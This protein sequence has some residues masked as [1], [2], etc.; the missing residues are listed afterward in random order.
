MK[1]GPL[2][3]ALAL[4]MG[5][6]MFFC[7][8]WIQRGAGSTKKFASESGNLLPELVWIRTSL[9]LTDSQFERVQALHLAY[10][11]KCD[12]L[13]RRIR[14]ADKKLLEVVKNAG[15]SEADLT[16]ALRARAE[17]RL[18]CHQAML[19]HVKGTAA[20]MNSEQARQY[21]DTVLPFVLGI[22]SNCCGMVD[23]SR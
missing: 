15:E 5:V 20:C 22:D 16:T 8:W 4:A 18:A 10:R 17:M 19:A 1:R 9:N 11:P 21:L 23:E 12:E 14:E 3:L 2:V 6:C 13:C 7:G